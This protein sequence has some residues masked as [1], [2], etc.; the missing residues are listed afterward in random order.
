MYNGETIIHERIN[1]IEDSKY[2]IMEINSF[3][4]K[5]KWNFGVVAD[6]SSW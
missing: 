5:V 6:V 1:E 4:Y 3:I 2:R